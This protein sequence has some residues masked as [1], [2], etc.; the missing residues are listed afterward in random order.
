MEQYCLCGTPGLRGQE[1][2]HLTVFIK[3]FGVCPFRTLHSRLLELS[4]VHTLRTLFINMHTS[5]DSRNVI[6]LTSSIYIN[7]LI[8]N[9]DLRENYCRNPDG[10]ES[11]WCFTTDPN[12]RIGYCSQIP[13]CD[14]SSGQGNSWHFAVWAW[15]N[16]GEIA[17]ER[18]HS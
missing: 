14:V 16:S 5:W 18:A 4:Q 13:K 17:K 12:I 6:T 15:L 7:M 9:R 10:A 2:W 1:N 11:P 8:F 3:W